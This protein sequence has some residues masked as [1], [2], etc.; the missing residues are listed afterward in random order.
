MK[1]IFA[2]T[3][4]CFFSLVAFSQTYGKYFADLPTMTVIDG[5]TYFVTLDG[6]P[7]VWKKFNGNTLRTY[8]NST[9][10]SVVN[11]T[12]LNAISAPYEGDLAVNTARDTLWIRATSTWIVFKAGTSGGG[13]ST[14][15]LQSV[16]AAGNSANSLKITNLATPTTGTDAA[17][18]SYVDTQISGVS[19]A[20]N[21]YS[22]NVAN[23]ARDT[24]I[25]RSQRT[26]RDS[27]ARAGWISS[28]DLATNSVSTIK[29]QN[30]AV[31]STKA[32]NLAP[33]DFNT[34][35]ATVGDVLTVTAS[36][37]KYRA[38]TGGA[39]S[40]S[41]GGDLTGTYPSP[42]IANN[43]IISA[44]VLDGTLVNADLAGQTLDSNKVKNRAIP[45]LKIA[46]S[47]IDSTR[48][49]KISPNNIAQNGATAGQA[50]VWDAVKGAYAPR[51]VSGGGGSPA[52]STG[53]VQYNNAGAFA[54][55]TTFKYLSSPASLE[56]G[57]RE[58]SNSTITTPVLRFKSAY[59][60]GTLGYGTVIRDYIKFDVIDGRPKA[61]NFKFSGQNTWNSGE[62]Y[63]NAVMKWGWFGG[64]DQN[65]SWYSMERSY[66]IGSDSSLA[67]IENHLAV[68]NVGRSAPEVRLFSATTIPNPNWALA[69][70]QWDFRGNQFNW[71][72]LQGRTFGV[73]EYNYN[74]SVVFSQSPGAY[75]FVIQSDSTSKTTTMFADLYS[76]T[77]PTLSYTGFSSIRM[78]NNTV[79]TPSTNTLSLSNLEVQNN[80]FVS[81]Q[82]IQ[83]ADVFQVK[84]GSGSYASAARFM[85]IGSSQTSL[86]LGINNGPVTISN[87]TGNTGVGVN[88]FNNLGSSAERNVAIA[89]YSG[90]GI[91]SG[92][93]NTLLGWATADQG[94]FSKSVVVGDSAMYNQALSNTLWIETQNKI[95]GN[96]TRTAPLISGKFA[97]TSLRGVGIETAP[98]NITST[99]VVTG[100]QSG[101]ILVVSA[102]VTLDA[103]H[104]TIIVPSGSSFVPTLPSA[105]SI[106]G[107]EYRIVNKTTGSIT[108]GSYVN[109]AGSTVTTIPTVTS[110]LLKSS[111]SGWEQVQ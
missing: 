17:N 94:N 60:Q 56:L 72:T 26:L 18:K 19:D 100:S 31:D 11:L 47:T 15:N 86:H 20:A 54:A 62:L 16:L 110:V 32:G 82:Q 99:F 10:T 58:T 64:N 85:G 103:T 61:A 40:G 92:Q 75:R 57:R 38:A 71:I 6:T 80:L 97:N 89:G 4:F 5:T 2:T 53:G 109:L 1:Q 95:V 106:T 25:A 66:A 83:F 77:A 49:S 43:S 37:V 73:M 14:P 90:R 8:V 39:P 33:S 88:T 70:S 50:L 87:A 27:L 69:R 9:V 93:G 81:G 108:V 78:A 51:N 28:T 107:R 23:L 13:G 22:I 12:A 104:H 65:A 63:P 76:S 52:G 24:A 34:S 79:F 42:T 48:I 36:G 59:P 21:I 102:N 41:A 111:G 105:T 84:A 91:T 55:D 101:S 29:I 45:G 30:T 98:A 7:K 44:Y 67:W 96:T 74:K 68:A 46:L 3:L 35:G